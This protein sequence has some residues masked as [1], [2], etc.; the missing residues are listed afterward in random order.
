MYSSLPYKTQ[1][2]Q[3][4]MHKFFTELQGLIYNSRCAVVFSQAM[5]LLHNS[6]LALSLTDSIPR[7][8]YHRYHLRRTTSGEETAVAMTTDFE[9]VQ[10]QEEEL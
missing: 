10:L 2:L 1:V 4:S 9:L 5:P 6:S 8:G 3:I 7:P